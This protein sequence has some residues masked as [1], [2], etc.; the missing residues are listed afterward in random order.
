MREYALHCGVREYLKGNI[1]KN[2]RYVAMMIKERARL[3]ATLPPVLKAPYKIPTLESDEDADD[4]SEDE[5]DV[6]SMDPAV[7]FPFSLPPPPSLQPIDVV[8]VPDEFEILAA[9]MYPVPAFG[10]RDVITGYTGEQIF[11][12]DSDKNFV[13]GHYVDEPII[14]QEMGVIGK[15]N[16]FFGKVLA[17]KLGTKDVHNVLI[18]EVATGVVKVTAAGDVFR[19]GKLSEVRSNVE[20]E[21]EGNPYWLPGFGENFGEIGATPSSTVSTT[22]A[23][24]FG[25]SF[26]PSD[27][28]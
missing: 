7:P 4:E 19:V 8:R 11:V 16:V 20:M 10:M 24:D 15:S 9:S 13:E 23:P 17:H 1:I 22:S 27:Y 5:P 14:G 25:P 21:D 3:D 26:A 6:V 28:G 2:P 18:S 12:R